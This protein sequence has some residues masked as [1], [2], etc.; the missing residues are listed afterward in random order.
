MARAVSSVNVLIHLLLA[1]QSYATEYSFHQGN[2]VPD[3][4]IYRATSCG[5]IAAVAAARTNS[6][7]SIALIESTRHVGG[8]TSSGLS[9]T[10]LRVSS[11]LGGLTK[12]FYSRAAINPSSPRPLVEPHTAETAY[13]DNA[14]KIF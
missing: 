9:A 14:H 12:E 7:I 8:M 3:I 2:V 11:I 6:S 4:V 10:D 5:V 1:A 13:Y